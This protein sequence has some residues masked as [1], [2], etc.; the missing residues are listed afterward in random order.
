MKK[1]LVSLTICFLF[2]SLSATSAVSVTPAK[3]FLEISSDPEDAPDWAVGNFTGEWGLNVWGNDWFAIGPVNGYYGNGFVG[4][5]KF[6]RFLITY[7]ESDGE[8]GTTF[9]G[10]FI[11][12][13]LL[14]TTTDIHIQTDNSSAF[15]GLGS[16]N[17]TAFRW[18]IMAMQ[19][20][21]L[22]MRGTFNGFE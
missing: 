22:F 4:S 17:E 21:T 13:Y 2:A 20:P 16:Y 8:N 6:G 9:Q 19:G 7:L 10:L 11:G 1:I 3:S 18:R 12:P 15:V 14:G 5:V